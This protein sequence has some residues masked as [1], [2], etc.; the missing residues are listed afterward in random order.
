M[1]FF[2]TGGAGRR[3]LKTG[4]LMGTGTAL[5]LSVLAV[6]PAAAADSSASIKA[7][8]DA[9]TAQINALSARDAAQAA[10]IKALNDQLQQLTATP[11][12]P[13]APPVVFTAPGTPPTF[14]QTNV[15]VQQSPGNV[16]G[17]S[18]YP[19][20]LSNGVNP[21]LGTAPFA[22]VVGTNPV[23]A[24]NPTVKLS[25]SGQ[26]DREE[27]YGNDGRAGEFRNLDNNISSTRFRFQ[28]ES[29]INSQTSAGANIE[30][31]IRPNSSSNTGLTPDGSN[32][33]TNFTGGIANVGSTTGAPA[34]NSTGVPTVRWAEA[35]ISNTEWG[36]LHLGFGGTA[37]YLTN[38]M[39]LSGTFYAGYENVS[40]TDGGFSFRQNGEAR[41]PA[42][43][44]N[45]FI[46]APS[47]AFGP[48]VGSVFFFFDGLVR[49]DRIRYNSP[50][51]NG[52]QFSTSAIDGGA[53]DFALRYGGNWYGTIV[54]AGG[55]ITLA[56]SLN[57]AAPN[58]YA[59][60]S[61]V[62]TVASTLVG[63][64]S[65]PPIIT[66]PSAAGSTQYNGSVSVLTPIGINL[67]LAGGYQD[68][69]Y[70]DPLHKNLSPDLIYAKLGWKTPTPW[71]SIGPT[72]FAVSFAQNDDLL[73]HGDTAKDYGVLFEQEVNPASMSVY[74]S[75]H[76]QT[77]DRDFGSYLPIDVVTAGGIVRF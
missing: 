77:L 25:L 74:M 73:Y 24:G 63:Q 52:F 66:G 29:W 19:P 53:V 32:S 12:T 13:P 60:S 11:P 69:I 34:S 49:N 56:T 20:E 58:A 71:F 21:A 76:H 2:G 39:D 35:F 41:V 46:T 17:R 26:V 67:T 62:P 33:V 47:G 48:A 18:G 3:R 70:Q 68:V 14:D 64:G 27:V 5:A 15:A 55:A 9:L 28:G 72:A 59:Y 61:G 44:G 22:A 1:E 8:L 51:W 57:H 4:L 75:Y 43:A 23:G 54:Q 6:T 45:T 7:Q 10:Q 30:L 16:P 40:D 37:G 31:E 65:T 42:G 36:A 50:Q 38:E